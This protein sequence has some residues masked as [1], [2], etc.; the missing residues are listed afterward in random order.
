MAG[1]KVN[2]DNFARAETDRMF[3][4]LQRDA[5]EVN[6]WHHSRVPT[7]L[8]HQ[9]VI[10]MNRDTLYSMA[11]V[12]ISAGAT[13]TIP[14]AGDRYASVMIVN[15]DHYINRIFHQSRD[16][17]LTVGDFD[18]PYVVA[19]ARVLV[20]PTNPDDVSV[21][22]AIQ[23]GFA[24]SAES[25]VP[26]VMPDY[27]QPSFDDTRTALLQL[28][29]G[30]GGT[31][32]MFGPKEAVDPVRHLIGTAAGWG[33]L[34]EQE[35]FYVIGESGL[36]VGEYKVTVRDVPVDAFWSISVYNA[37][38]FFEP[39]DRNTNSINS[40]TATPDA[41][42]SVTVHFGECDDRP[43]CIPIMEGWNYAVRLYRPR[44]E[45]IDGSWTFPRVEGAGS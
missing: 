17:E 25:D 30:V 16:Y 40:V 9:T 41:D 2:V 15:Q 31:A 27:D 14:D 8:D 19:A 23:D 38:G 4:A 21:V 24:L 6:R 43:N 42:G 13:I 37:E 12:D 5:G 29:K 36:P 7:P 28:A 18:T 3:S 10:R 20:D 1:V 34:P 32:G 26:F 33:G 45:V 35:A 22:N 39:N 44:P 11:V